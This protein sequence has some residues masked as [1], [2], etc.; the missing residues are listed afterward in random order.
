ML[1]VQKWQRSW[2]WV[3]THFQIFH[4]H[5]LQNCNAEEKRDSVT[6][7]IYSQQGGARST[8]GRA[9]GCGKK[10]TREERLQHETRQTSFVSYKHTGNTQG[11]ESP[12]SHQAV[13]IA[14]I[15]SSHRLNN[16]PNITDI[17]KQSP[18]DP[19]HLASING[20]LRSLELLGSTGS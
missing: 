1:H 10:T 20:S 17:S 8:A 3:L 2:L 16:I 9:V 15:S 4:S 7:S 14:A 11:N 13:P 6:R 19:L 12:L 18:V 5:S